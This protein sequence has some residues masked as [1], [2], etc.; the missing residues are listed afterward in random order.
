MFAFIGITQDWR[1]IQFGDDCGMVKEAGSVTR[2]FASDHTRS[3]RTLFQDIF[4]KSAFTEVPAPSFSSV[5]MGK[6]TALWAVKE[7]SDA[8]ASP[9]YLM[10]PLEHL[11]EPWIAQ[12]LIHRDHD[13]DQPRVVEPEEADVDMEEDVQDLTISRVRRTRVVD[14]EEMDSFVALF[15]KHAVTC[16][17]L[18]PSCPS[19]LI[20]LQHIHPL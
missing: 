16:M 20:L 8:F 14:Q 4:G 6:R 11:F 5:E 2:G 3:P 15:R 19:L 12:F 18:A 13:I 7:V 17:S 1:V 10:P 9:T